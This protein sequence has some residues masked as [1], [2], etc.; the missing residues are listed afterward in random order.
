VPP[1]REWSG[2]GFDHM[3]EFFCEFVM[4]NSLGRIANSHIAI[5]DN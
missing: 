2:T 3:L 5:A 1:S 4:N